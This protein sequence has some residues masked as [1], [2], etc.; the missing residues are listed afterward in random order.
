MWISLIITVLGLLL[1]FFEF[2]IPGG[3]A[4][5]LGGLMIVIGVTTFSILP[6]PLLIKGAFFVCACGATAALCSF[7]L[8]LIRRK[9]SESLQLK[10]DQEGFTSASS[11]KSLIG[12]SGVA[13][14]DLKPSGFVLVEGRRYQ[15]VSQG[16]YLKKGHPIFVEEGRGA[17]LIVSSQ[18]KEVADANRS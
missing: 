13:I 4:A 3:I 12:L 15:A 9:G 11:D 16:V 1:I 18:Q 17:T 10:A 7:A 8:F 6:I 14:S 2:F 5:I